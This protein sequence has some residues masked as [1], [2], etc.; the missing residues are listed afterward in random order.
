MLT[1][2]QGPVAEAAAVQSIFTIGTQNQSAA[3]FALSPNRY[4]SYPTTYPNDVTYTVG[5]STAANWSY[6]HPG[7]SDAWAGSKNHTFTINYSLTS[8]Q[9]T[10]GT[11]LQLS[12]ADTHS[13]SPTVQIK[14][15]GTVVESL[16]VPSGASV[17]AHGR[18]RVNGLTNSLNRPNQVGFLI[19]ATALLTGTN[20]IE[21]VSTAGS[22]AVYDSVTM[23]PAPATTGAVQVV[24]L[25]PTVFLKK[26]GTVD[27]HVVDIGVNNTSGASGSVVFAATLG[28]RT[29]TTTLTVPAGR[30]IQRILVPPAPVGGLSQVDI[31]ATLGTQSGTYG[32]NLPYQKRWQI[33][34]M[35]GPH[36]DNGY[37]YDQ[38]TTRQI[39]NAYVDQAVGQCNTTADPAKGY[40]DAEKFRWT[41]ESSWV[42]NNYLQDRSAAQIAALAT[43]VQ[44]GQIDIV[45]NYNHNLQDLAT[46][47][48]MIRGLAKGTKDLEDQLGVSVTAAMQDDVTGVSAQYIQ[49]LA[50]Q[51]VKVL[52]NGTNPGHTG[53]NN[54]AYAGQDVP[55]LFNWEA[56]NGSKV[57]TFFGLNG[58]FEG[59]WGIPGLQCALSARMDDCGRSGPALPYTPKAPPADL[60]SVTNNVA[61]WIGNLLP[62]LQVGQY[63]QSVYPLLAFADTAPP[64]NGVSD[65]IKKYASQYSYPRLVSST[66]SRF[67]ADAT[68]PAGGTSV[69]GYTPDPTSTP[70]S[71]LPVKTGDYT[72]WWSD[73]AGSSP[74]ETGDNMRSQ[75]RTTAAETLGSLAGLTTQDPTRTCMVDAAYQQQN[76]WTEHTWGTEGL[77]YP[78]TQWPR[79]KI[80]ADRTTRFSTNALTS[81]TT[82]LAKQIANTGTNPGLSV[83]NPQSW[84]RTDVVTATVASG[85][86]GKLVDAGSGLAVPYQSVDSTHIQ[87]VA[88]SVPAVGYKRY[89]LETGTDTSTAPDSSLSW[90]ATTRVLQN[91]HYTVTFSTTG[92]ISSIVERATSKELVDT[93]SS[94]KLNQYVYRPNAGRS[95][96]A[97]GGAPTSSANQW[98]PASATLSVKSTGKVGITISVTYPNTPGGVD[99][100]NKATGVESAGATITLL[101]NTPRVDIVN[102]LNKTAVQT[103]EEGYFAFPFEVDSPAVTYEGNG[104]PV[105]LG[106]DQFPGAAMDWQSTLGYADA[107]AT[108]G[109]VTLSTTDA[110]LIEFGDIKTMRLIARPG[111]IDGPVVTDLS[112]V[113]PTNGSMFSWAFN[114]LWTTNYNAAYPGPMSFHYSI[115]SHTGGFNATNATRFSGGVQSPLLV[116]PLTAGQTGSYTASSQSLASVD[117]S[118]VVLST[119]KQASPTDSTPAFPLTARLLEVAGLSGS[120][121]LDVPFKVSSAK[122]LDLADDPTTAPALTVTDLGTGSRIAVPYGKYGIVSVGIQ[123]TTAYTRGAP[124]V[125]MTDFALAPDGHANYSTAFP[126]DVSYTAKQAASGTPDST[127]PASTTPWVNAT[128]TGVTAPQWSYIQPGPSDAWAGS[129]QHTFKLNFTLPAAPTKDLTLTLWL[130]DTHNTAPPRLDV[131]VNQN[132]AVAT[133]LPAGGGDGYRWGDT[134]DTAGAY[135]IVPRAVSFT[136]PMS[137]LTAGSNTVSLTNAVGSWL[138][139][140]GVAIG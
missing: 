54:A 45:G 98:S 128:G 28:A 66:P 61:G 89:R 119:I 21:I 124:K 7:P 73:G 14:S 71:A 94:F 104:M 95:N 70:V 62:G 114:N 17:G 103:P 122:L 36:F 30:S 31:K 79:K 44:S 57:L 110:P 108:T 77:T 93:A 78:S 3:E 97:Y 25:N 136:L 41:T 111:Q 19:P 127:Y 53:A 140:D 96:T 12:Y 8:T 106:R 68:T 137:Q 90:N 39:L 67:H 58:Y 46:S 60:T 35:H 16:K 115:T 50:Q 87:F 26:S 6:I 131:S 10:N 83:F 101:A 126:N 107:S 86:A 105:Q 72:G 120:A 22:Y 18:G 59:Y 55:T 109:G 9:R 118:N 5:T 27:A 130:I 43:C 91:Q 13:V 29:E 138:V 48:N 37:H 135:K 123:P 88:A 52:I 92:A 100:A 80:Y 33:D 121:N 76:M 117:D 99:A 34:L 81:A 125:C 85:W 2:V 23:L 84:P 56:P 139:Y 129:K 75:I 132:A 51:G 116:A 112:G 69:S 38:Q 102:S 47:E 49:M 134:K 40:T 74:V 63:P 11:L 24:S 65:V 32:L 20:K 82:A 4:A 133:Q 15:N 42:V 1:A 64:L 113:L